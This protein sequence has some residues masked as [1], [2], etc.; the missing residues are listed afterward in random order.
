LNKGANKRTGHVLHQKQSRVDV[1][2]DERQHLHQ[3]DRPARGNTEGDSSVAGR[4]S[5]GHDPWCPRRLRAPHFAAR[6][7]AFQGAAR[8]C[9]LQLRPYLAGQQNKIAGD[10]AIRFGHK[11][12]SAEFET[13][14]GGDGPL[15][16]QR[17]HHHDWADALVE[18]HLQHADAVQLRHVDIHADDVRA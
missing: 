2:G 18:D 13:L 7:Q 9:R 5:G 11:I 15:L 14:K 6:D 4:G 8:H 17:T 10:G 16:R 12:E 3:G 1:S